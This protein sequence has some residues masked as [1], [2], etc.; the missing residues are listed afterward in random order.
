[1]NL[2][3]LEEPQRR[4]EQ[5]LQANRLG[6]APLI[7]GPA[8]LG[9]LE[10]ARWLLARILCLSPAGEAPC[11]QCRSCE[12]LA[13]GSHPDSFRL[14]IPEDKKEIPVDDV[15]G[16]I[17]S[18]QLT[19][20]VGPNRVGLIEPAEAM[21]RNAANALLKTLEEPAEKAW[22]ILVSHQPGRLPAT[23]RSRC[24]KIV[25]RPPHADQASAWLVDRHPSIEG[26]DLDRVLTLAAGAPLAASALLAGDGLD[27]GRQILEGLLAVAAGGSASAVADDSWHA[28]P[29]LTWHWLSVWMAAI[30]RH[31]Q[32]LPDSA[33]PATFKLPAELEPQSLARLWEQS[34]AGRRMSTM[35]VRHDLLIGKWLLEWARCFSPGT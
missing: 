23:I 17:A 27:H 26:A 14:A 24:Q 30:M 19:P 11:G 7:C 32:G 35:A 20:R 15:R 13:S 34:L 22:L 25:I 16:M 18:L 28:S 5:T 9:K 3:W 6:H 31:A 10:L 4:L 33:L 21:N 29:E 12:L 8:G 1:M 2:P